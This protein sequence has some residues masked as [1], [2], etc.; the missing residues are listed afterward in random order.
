MHAMVY[1]NEKIVLA[2]DA[3][4]AAVSA[5]MLYARGVFTT[6]AVYGGRPFQWPQHWQRLLDHST[7]IGVDTGEFE[8]EQVSAALS[9]L[10][11]ANKV[12]D[13]RAR[14]TLLSRNLDRGPWK[15]EDASMKPARL[16][17]LL[18][19]TGEPRLPGSDSLALTVSPYR[20]NT[21]SPL[22]GL[23]S[24]NYLDHLLAHEEARARGFDEAVRLNERGEVVSATLANIFWVT[25]GRLHTPALST[26]ALAGT[27][28]AR[29]IEL[30]H[31][32][33][34][35]TQEGVYELSDLGDA[36][37]IFLTSS[38]LAIAIVTTFDFH[39][40]TVP[41]GSIALRLHEAFR[42]LIFQ[43]DEPEQD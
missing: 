4:V 6:L 10:I 13:G 35:P 15:P 41:I 2:S 40:Y 39:H 30:A 22:A 34:I 42:Q 23:K 21:H 33:S 20:A 19:M 3:R 29:L 9:E 36:H 43:A 8:E 37:E 38:A 5:A 1:L 12:S 16:T 11:A 28:R 26:G 14:V 17:D 25:D 18:I 7:R 24:L 27:T 32:L 31:E